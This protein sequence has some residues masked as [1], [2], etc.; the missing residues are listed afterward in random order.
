MGRVGCWGSRSVGTRYRVY[1]MKTLFAKS[2]KVTAMFAMS[3]RPSAWNSSAPSGRISMK[4][5]FSV[6]LENLDRKS[7][8][9]KNMTRM[10]GTLYEDVCTCVAISRSVLL[11]MRNIPDKSCR[12]NQN[13]HF[14]FSNFFLLSK[15]VPF[16]R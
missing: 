8:F 7:K 10:T 11:R 2:R 14:V 15:I 3:V 9:R 16:M 6:L 4:F 12:G 5:D 13:T 1:R